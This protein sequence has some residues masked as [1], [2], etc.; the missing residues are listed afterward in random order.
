M[1][2]VL[3][4][5]VGGQGMVAS[6]QGLGCMVIRILCSLLS[7][8]ILNNRRCFVS[9][10]MTTAFGIVDRDAQDEESLT[11]I[12]TALELGVNMLDTAWIYQVYTG[13]VREFRT[14]KTAKTHNNYPSIL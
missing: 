10:G 11:T 7:D 6:A 1:P 2:C 8:K 14:A 13:T 5:R 3:Q 4:R 12:A 9:Q